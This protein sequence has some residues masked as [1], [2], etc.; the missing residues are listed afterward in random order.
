MKKDE[1][2][3][4][5]KPLPIGRDNFKQIIDNNCYYVDKTKLIEDLLNAGAYVTLFPRPRRFGKSLMLSTIDEFFNVE[6]KQDNEDLF[7]GL[8]IGKSTYVSEQGKYPVIKLNLKSIESNSWEDMYSGFKEIIRE[9]FSSKKYL[10]EILDD[11]EKALFQKFTLKE[12]DLSEYKLSLKIL[13]NFLFR[14]YNQKVIL[15]IDEYDVPIQK[16]YIKGFYSNIIDF[17]KGLFNNALKS[18]D[19]IQF[20]VMTGVLR[21]SK[22]SI[23]SDL[24]NVKVY[25]IMNNPYDEYF[26]FT[27]HETA[28]FLEY[29]N[30]SLTPEVKS[31]YDG[32]IFGEKE[33][34]NP[35]SIINY[36]E[37]GL[38]FPYWVNTSSDDV[39]KNIFEKTKNETKSIL[40][41]LILGNSIECKY[42]V[43]SNK[44]S[45]NCR[46]D[47][48][49]E[50][51]DRSL[52]IVFE[53]KVAKDDE[54]LEENALVGKD[55]ILNKKYFKE[56]EL[57]RV[58][59]VITYGVAFRGKEC[60]VV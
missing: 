48:M 58:Q 21:V 39:L 53:F 4:T 27:E 56:L 3:V 40:E 20:A 35:W 11:A 17:I 15:L 23:F 50:A 44:E 42:I 7:D 34:Y 26:G 30:L 2:G 54:S 1:K 52:G 59:N 9:L 13:S 55:Q 29:Y 45:G 24:N 22:E 18:N 19:N 47:I 16:G 38:L 43:K 51:V 14:Y 60:R 41:E 28:E 25:S 33:I 12:A 32:Y 8:Y 36:A 31:M 5:M 49:I 37:E 46:F 10:L 57:D 6:K